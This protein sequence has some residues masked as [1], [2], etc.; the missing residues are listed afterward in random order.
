MLDSSITE[1]EVIVLDD[2][3]PSVTLLGH[4]G[5]D[6]RQGPFLNWFTAEYHSVE[7]SAPMSRLTVL[8]YKPFHKT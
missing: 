8:D 5:L 6:T 7:Y 4:T 3:L 1:Q 2:P